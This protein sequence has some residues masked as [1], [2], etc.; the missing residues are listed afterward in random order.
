MHQ[1][2]AAPDQ[3]YECYVPHRRQRVQR[4][5]ETGDF[6]EAVQGEENVPRET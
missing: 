6:G 3:L 1:G 4:V 2:H 5:S